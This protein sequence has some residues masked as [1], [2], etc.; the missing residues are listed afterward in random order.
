[1]SRLKT[2]LHDMFS[3]EEDMADYET[4]HDNIEKG[5]SIRGTNF[6]ILMMAI[7]VASI[8][9]NMNS[10]AVI[11]GAML[12]SPLMGGIMAIGYGAAIL[13]WDLVKK[14]AVILFLEV[15]ISLG[16]STAYFSLSPISTAYSELLARTNPTVWDVLI[17]FFG[18]FAGIIGFTRKEKGNVIPGVAIATALMPPL[19]TAGFGLANRSLSYLLGA[20]YLFFINSFFIGLATYIAVKLLRVPSKSFLDEKKR[21]RFK[22]NL[23]I[24]TIIVLTPSVYLAYQIVTDSIFDSNMNS[25]IA[26]SFNFDDTQ[27][28][29]TNVDKK[30]KVLTVALIG[31][32]I[33]TGVISGM[34]QDM[35]KYNLSGWSLKVNQTLVSQ[36]ISMEDVE[37]LIDSSIT[38]SSNSISLQQSTEITNLNNQIAALKA[39]LLEY[40]AADVDVN[41]LAAELAALYPGIT[42]VEAGYV[43][44]VEFIKTGEPFGEAD[45]EQD[46]GAAEGAAWTDGTGRQGQDKREFLAILHTEQTLAEEELT[47]I[48]EWI[49]AKL[50]IEDVQIVQVSLQ[51]DTPAGNTGNALPGGEAEP[52]VGN[53]RAL[54]GENNNEAGEQE[55][56]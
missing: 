11:I 33:D 24:A 5:A 30:N 44:R 45:S 53:D 28:V 26:H 10:T 39:Q 2:F 29:Q 31:Q 20:L 1:M 15:V 9:L 42:A 22:R 36:G 23:I 18:G 52:S 21:K 47:R 14:S 27:V 13:D 46:A 55:S 35:E 8:G 12:I 32:T 4:I 43:D 49:C 37:S 25:Y 54:P 40:Q 7:F 38:N 19:C 50:S 3:L 48:E 41:T 17:A 6:V 34:E 56:R 16:V 51:N